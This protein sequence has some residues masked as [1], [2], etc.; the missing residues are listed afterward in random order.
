MRSVLAVLVALCLVL[1]GCGA[2][3][4][5]GDDTRTVNPALRG[6]PT[7]SPT[8]NA[9]A[10]PP[11]VGESEVDVRALVAAHRDALSDRSV[12]VTLSRTRTSDDGTVVLDTAVRSVSDPPDQFVESRV[13]T[14]PYE[15]V[16]NGSLDT[17]VWR[18]DTVSVRRSDAGEGSVS[19]VYDTDVP[20]QRLFGP[21]GAAEI[22]A[23]LG[24]YTL[25]PAGTVTENGT[26]Y[27]RLVDAAAGRQR[28]PLRSNV[29]V[30][31]LVTPAGVIRTATVSYRTAEYE[32]PARV[33]VRFAVRNV[34]R[35]TVP[36]PNWAAAALHNES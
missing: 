21:T 35:T 7:P 29:S 13:D 8:P 16:G 31:L 15:V 36:R 3:T 33:T 34:S 11:G 1:A 4:T 26:R 14:T 22:R 27:R 32:E 9:A 23:V 5:P 19:V 12:T 30:E 10:R 6:T 18:N 20:Q 25:T 17:A 24:P 28:V 2:T